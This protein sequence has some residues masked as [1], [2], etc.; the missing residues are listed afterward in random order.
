MVNLTVEEKK[1][2]RE[3]KR[4][5]SLLQSGEIV[6][7]LTAVQNEIL[8]LR[9]EVSAEV[10]K[11][12][13]KRMVRKEYVIVTESLSEKYF[14]EYLTARLQG[15]QKSKLVSKTEVSRAT[16]FK[17]IKKWESD[18]KKKIKIDEVEKEIENSL[19]VFQ[20]YKKFRRLK[21][22][23]QELAFSLDVTEMELER[24]FKIWENNRRRIDP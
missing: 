18:P 15:F 11:E 7:D 13:R 16:Y 21:M 22:T 20:K 9:G 10:I 24:H 17:L 2:L 1:K 8:T 19:N 14:N 3:L 12:D 5:R 23:L 6:G 4:L